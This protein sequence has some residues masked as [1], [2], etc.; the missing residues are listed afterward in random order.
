MKKDFAFSPLAGL[1]S[2]VIS[3]PIRMPLRVLIIEAV[4]AI[5]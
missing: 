1:P 5:S 2:Q 4:G 3:N